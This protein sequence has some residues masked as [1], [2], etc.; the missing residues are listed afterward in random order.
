MLTI[1]IIKVILCVFGMH[2]VGLIL[3]WKWLR[4]LRKASAVPCIRWTCTN[5]KPCG[6]WRLFNNMIGI[7][8]HR[9]YFIAVPNVMWPEA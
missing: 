9:C 2:V 6:E 1:N 4:K 5:Q 7:V 3:H 8:Y